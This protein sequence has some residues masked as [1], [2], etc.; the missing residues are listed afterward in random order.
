MIFSSTKQTQSK[1]KSKSKMEQM[2]SIGL[3]VAVKQW[4]DLVNKDFFKMWE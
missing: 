3:N 4:I 1:T 2:E